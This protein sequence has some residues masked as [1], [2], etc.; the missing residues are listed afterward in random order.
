MNT[1][2]VTLS[3]VQNPK[4]TRAMNKDRAQDQ[5]EVLEG[6]PCTRPWLLSSS[7][8]KV[9]TMT[10]QCFGNA[11]KRHLYLFFTSG[12]GFCK[13]NHVQRWL[14]KHRAACT[15][16]LAE[17][18]SE[19]AQLLSASKKFREFLVLPCVF[20]LRI[21]KPKPNTFTKKNS[22]FCTFK[23]DAKQS[24]LNTDSY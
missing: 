20:L 5:G 6:P 4:D 21:K 11:I 12:N 22:I 14:P 19:N 7:T 23:T 1:K 15:A 18:E 9:M 10:V 8:C 24:F 3:A 2:S 17:L 13:E 16:P